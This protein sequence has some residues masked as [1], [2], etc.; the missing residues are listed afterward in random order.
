[1]K[2]L[3]PLG[4]FT[5]A[6]TLLGCGIGAAEGTLAGAA[7]APTTH[8]SAS[9]LYDLGNQAAR[10]DKPALAVLNYERALVLAPNDDDVRTNLDAVLKLAG[11]AAEPAGWLA[12]HDRLAAPNLMYWAGLAGLVLFGGS[13]L[14]A[15]LHAPR[16]RALAAAAIIGAAIAALS[17]EDAVATMPLLNEAVVMQAS[18]AGA[19]PV[20]DAE[21]QFTFPAAEVVHIRDHHAGFLLIED[22]QHRE[23]WVPEANVTSVIPA[24]SRVIRR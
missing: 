13:L 3:T 9:A 6:I 1:M 19:S 11:V 22:S 16:R 4:A 24:S 21:S 20:L 17:I 18:P 7:P 14:A 10:A 5:L 12:R 23:G 2:K 8:Y 15:R